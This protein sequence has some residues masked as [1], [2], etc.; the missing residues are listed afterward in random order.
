[1]TRPISTPPAE[2]P[3]LLSIDA[4]A[5]LLALS[6]G[7]TRKLIADGKLDVV[8]LAGRRM[9]PRTSVERLAAGGTATN[10]QAAA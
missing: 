6:V 7:T 3:L 2:R 10:A 8:R 9:V 1:M 4:A 5:G